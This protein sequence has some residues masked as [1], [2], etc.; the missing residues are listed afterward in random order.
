LGGHAEKTPQQGR[1]LGIVT[2]QILASLSRK[3]KRFELEMLKDRP[4]SAARGSGPNWYA[5]DGIE[6]TEWRSFFE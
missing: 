6:E 4:G 2:C 5:T 1:R 3:N